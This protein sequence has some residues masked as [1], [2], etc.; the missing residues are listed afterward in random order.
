RQH[1]QPGRALLRDIAT[2]PATNIPSVSPETTARTTTPT[3]VPGLLGGTPM[4]PVAPTPGQPAPE[5]LLGPAPDDAT[6][7]AQVQS[8][9]P[10]AQTVPGQDMPY[11][12]GVGIDPTVPTTAPP[13]PV[14]Q[15][16]DF[17]RSALENMVQP[18]PTPAL[19]PAEQRLQDVQN[20]GVFSDPAA[21]A[22]RGLVP[23]TPPTG[24]APNTLPSG[25]PPTAPSLPAPQIQ[26]MQSLPP[27]PEQVITGTQPAPATGVEGMRQMY[28]GKQQ[29]PFTPG[30]PQQL[31]QVPDRAPIS[32]APVAPGSARGLPPAGLPPGL[33]GRGGGQGGIPLI[34]PQMAAGGGASPASR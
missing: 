8:G 15:I 9:L 18:A 21:A 17:Y 2:P 14:T 24:P 7:I 5:S 32:R 33:L 27:S 4:Q 16:S 3:T 11:G 22:R 23:G 34:P 19:S 26:T 12:I 25:Y 29:T 10:P 13:A 20:Y 1:T 31:T 6:R 28:Q 30:T